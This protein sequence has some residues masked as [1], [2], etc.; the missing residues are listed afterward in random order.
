MQKKN[1]RVKISDIAEAVGV[2]RSTVCYALNGKRSISA[3][4][5]ER[6]LREI[7]RQ[8]YM[9]NAIARSFVTKR[10]NTIGL[11][12]NREIDVTDLFMLAHIRGIDSVISEDHYKILLLN[13]LESHVVDDYSI[14]IDQT[15]AI[16]GAIICNARNL[17]L[18]LKNFEIERRLFVLMGKPPHGADVYYVDND[19][20]DAA[21]RAVCSF[22]ARGLRRVALVVYAAHKTTLNLDY[23]TGYTNAHKDYQVE[24]QPE[25][26]L[27]AQPSQLDEFRDL[28]IH[29]KVD[30]VLMLSPDAAFRRLCFSEENHGIPVVFFGLDLYREFLQANV[31]GDFSYIESNAQA[32]GR[33]CAEVLMQLIRGEN[34]PKAT[35]LKPKILPLNL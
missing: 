18:Y 20:Q 12:V 24:F 31:S 21:Y 26:V 10:T 19:N 5:K 27:R 32:L 17:R 9:P 1:E 11:Y 15:F 29:K 2:S 28:M 14:P 3:E 30:A 13:E 23:I 7:D 25:L 4:A 6:I 35:I 8:G 33:T 16:D 34:P 22:F